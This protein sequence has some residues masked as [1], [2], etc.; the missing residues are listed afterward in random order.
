MVGA[1][2]AAHSRLFSSAV[3]R[4]MAAASRSPL[5][6]RLVREAFTPAQFKRFRTVGQCLDAAFDTLKS[7]EHRDEY[8]YK[9]ALTHR[10]LLGRHSLASASMLTEFRVGKCK[11]DLV[12]L[13]GT[14]TVYEIKSER[15]SLARLSN[16]LE[17]YRL[18]FPKRCVIAGEN[19]VSSILSATPPEVG[20]LLLSDRYRI[21]TVR[22]AAERFEPLCP[23][24]MC[25]ALRVGE[26]RQVL[27][28]LGVD[29]PD[30]PNTQLR[31]ELEGLFA[32]ADPRQLHA[33]M[34]IVLK[35]ARNL[36]PLAALVE[37]LPVS[38][39]PAAL[40]VPMRMADHARLVQAV[41][42]RFVDAMKWG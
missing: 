21:Q 36:A 16:Q 27:A 2:L 11:A 5:F 9:A 38:L 26:A 12:I 37:E 39:Q 8:V 4:Q 23:R 19:H 31:S 22:E 34:V 17:A 30:V 1:Q 29:V 20:V 24:T 7:V 14:A 40:T 3:V 33:Q 6:A 10:V 15:D 41:R 42:T 13:N 32:A 35:R 18:V 25:D 28:N